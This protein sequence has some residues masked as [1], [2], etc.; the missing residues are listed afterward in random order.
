MSGTADTRTVFTWGLQH[1]SL[2]NVIVYCTIPWLCN[3][4]C[5]SVHSVFSQPRCTAGPCEGSEGDLGHVLC[6]LWFVVGVANGYE[7][8]LP[9]LETR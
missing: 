6:K 3:Y 8:C 7:K 1:G 9:Y 4:V 5:C 2:Y